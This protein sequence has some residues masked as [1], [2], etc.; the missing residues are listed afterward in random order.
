MKLALVVH[1]CEL[2]RTLKKYTLV[3]LFII[4][5]L[6]KYTY[7]DVFYLLIMCKSMSK[8]KYVQVST[9]ADQK[10]AGTI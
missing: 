10:P 3:E 8:C 9:G 7:K 5:Q 1:P 2:E 4:S 6:C